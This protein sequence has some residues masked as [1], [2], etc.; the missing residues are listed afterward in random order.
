MSE[1]QMGRRRAGN[2]DIL[3]ERLSILDAVRML[4]IFIR[5]DLKG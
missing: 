5:R 1:L 4:I 2:M 3:G